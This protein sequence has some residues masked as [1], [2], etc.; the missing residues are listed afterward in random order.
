MKT[1]CCFLTAVCLI[2]NTLTGQHNISQSPAA[3]SFTLVTDT[4]NYF[5]NK[6]FFKL[7]NP[8]GLGF[9][10][11]KSAAATNTSISHMGSVFLNTDPN[12]QVTGLEARLAYRYG[13][14]APA[15]PVNLYLFSVDQN[16][17]PVWPA[18]DSITLFLGSAQTDTMVTTGFAMSGS[19]GSTLNPVA[20]NITGNF[21]VLVRNYSTLS[22]DTVCVYRTSSLTQTNQAQSNLTNMGEDLGRIR[23][24]GQFFKT[25]NFAYTGFGL[26]TDFEFCVAPIVTFSLQASHLAP[27]QVN[28]QPTDT[29]DCFAPLT[30]TNTS[31]PQFTNRFF[32]LNEF[33]R[34]FW[35]YVNTPPGG[36]SS[37]S[38]ISWYFDDEDDNPLLRP[39][40]VLKK[41]SIRATKYY[42][43]SGCF[44]SCSLRAR[45]R[46]MTAGGSSVNI[47]GNVDFSV[48]VKG[49]YVGIGEQDVLNNLTVF[50][51]PVQQGKI[52]VLGLRSV[53][54]YSILDARGTPIRKGV[55]GLLSE[56][57]DVADLS[58][59]LYLLC[60]T[61]V[62]N[63]RSIK[64][65]V[66]KE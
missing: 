56:E 63:T 12:L 40:L 65:F 54:N 28:S 26:G 55:C 38:A 46:K 31:S 53:T 15:I 13:S 27:P 11:Y 41:D 24:N 39:N 47:R 64:F 23:Y 7:P 29:V 43:T 33:Y 18:I 17:M 62:P 2:T 5:Y 4:L 6:Q 10:F 25:R 21:A 49:C 58:N 37:D 3:S 60:L 30:F 44:T 59:G 50:P 16:L 1:R 42:D 20:Y 35:P 32:N 51:N 36:F 8:T 48:C 34:H 66:K 9:P 61:Q 57:I 14:N 45:Y 19:F 52:R 22:G